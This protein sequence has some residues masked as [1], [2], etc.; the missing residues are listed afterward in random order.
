MTQ[1]GSVIIKAP[2]ACAKDEAWGLAAPLVFK[3][4]V[5]SSK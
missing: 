3:Y 2:A 4:D 5:V 1:G